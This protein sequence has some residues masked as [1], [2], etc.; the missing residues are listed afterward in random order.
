MKRTV[1][2]LNINRVREIIGCGCKD[3]HFIARVVSEKRPL[4]N[5][6]RST[7]PTPIAWSS[8]NIGDKSRLQCAGMNRHEAEDERALRVKTSDLL[9][10]ESCADTARD[11]VKRRQGLGEVGIQLRKD[12]I[13]TPPYLLCAV[14]NMSRSASA[15]SCTVRRSRRPQTR[16]EA[17]C[18][19]TGRPRRHLPPNQAAVRWA[20]AIAA[21]PARTSPRRHTAA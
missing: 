3:I 2:R 17:S 13:R 8:S 18:T 20:E 19:R 7:C 4:N 21:R 10:P 5:T 9:G 1:I 16:L 11:S 15:S 14:G 6:S 12:A